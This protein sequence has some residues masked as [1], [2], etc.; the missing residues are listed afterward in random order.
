MRVVIE[1]ESEALAPV[2]AFPSGESYIDLRQNPRAIERI[3]PARAHLPLRN[4]LSAINCTKSVFTSAAVATESRASSDRL[5]GESFEFVSRIRLVFAILSLNFDRI[6]YTEIMAALK[7]LLER[8]SAESIRAVLHVSLCDFPE[9]DRRGFCLEIQLI[10]RGDSPQQAEVRWDWG[11]LACS[12]LFYSVLERWGSRSAREILK[13]SL[14]R[15]KS[16]SKSIK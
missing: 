1:D 6:Q 13:N 4:F 5:S 11:W 12:R 10:A 9:Q 16:S 14:P 2:P 3:A 8:D 15:V 7:E